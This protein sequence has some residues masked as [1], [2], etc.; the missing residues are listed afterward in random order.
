[1]ILGA[2]DFIRKNNLSRLCPAVARELQEART[3]C[4][5]KLAQKALRESENF[6]ASVFESI[7]D[8]IS[9]LDTN[10]TII[11][12][13]TTHK[14]WHMHKA[15]WVGKK[16][17][18]VFH[19]RSQPCDFCPARQSLS[20]GRP[21]SLI[22]PKKDHDKHVGWLEVFTFPLKDEA[23]GEI[24][25][26]IEYARDITIRKMLEQELEKQRIFTQELL[27]YSPIYFVAID[28]QGKTLLM[29]QSLLDALGYTKREVEGKDYL[30]TFVP[31]ADR[32]ALAEVFD[33][34]VRLQIPTINENHILAKNGAQ[35]LVEWH[36]RP[37]FKENGQLDYFFGVGVDITARRKDQAALQASEEKY[38][39]ILETMEEGYYEVDLAGNTLFVNDAMCRIM[40]YPKE[41]LIGMNNRQYTDPETAK[42][43]YREFNEVY[44]TEKP[45][46]TSEHEILRKDG[47]KIWIE[48]SITLRRDPSG[49]K[50]GF[51][52]IV[53]DI[54]QRK[55]A[56]E[57]LR[58]RDLLFKKL[59]L[60]V[61]G[62]IYQF[63]RKPDGTYCMP[64][65]TEAIGDL[66]GCS[67]QDVQDDFS[68]LAQAICPEDFHRVMASIENSAAQMTIW[69]CEFRVQVPGQPLKWIFGQ[70]TPEKLP[71]G[72]ILWHGFAADITERK[73]AQEELRKS[74]EEL[75][76][77]IE[78]SPIMIYFKDT[79]NRFIRVNKALLEQTGLS[80]EEIEGKSNEE[81]NP[82]LAEKFRWE[83]QEIIATG[84]PLTGVLEEIKTRKGT[85][86]LKTDKVPYRDKNGKIIGIV[87]FSV[88]ITGQKKAQDALAES[89]ARYRSLVKNAQEGVYQSTAEGKYLMVN[90]A[91]ARI[92]GYDS[93]YELMQTVTDI[94]QH[95]YVHPD[96]RKRLLKLVDRYGAV[97]DFE[98]EFY[99]K[100]GTRVWLSV[101]MHAVRDAQGKILHY[102]GMIQDITEK[103]KM[104][105]ERQ[106]HLRKIRKA[107]GA[108]INAMAVAVETRDPYTA[109]HQ[110]RV[111]DLARAIATEM[112]LPA[113][114]IEGLRM[115]SIIHD[116]GKI[117]IP[118]EILTKPTQLSQLEYNL[119]KTHPSSGYAI[120]KDIE[121]P[122]PIARIVLEHH[123]RIDGSG[124]PAGLTGNQMLT[125]SK[126]LAVADVVEAISSHRPYRAAY[127]TEAALKEIERGRGTL[128][129]ADAVDACL[130]LFREKHYILAA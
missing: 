19:G 67:P 87:G 107:L 77:M 45:G 117:S 24:R 53:R 81:I 8:G 118:S 27:D 91:F 14:K 73:S 40:G 23:T 70:S 68:P 126:I 113:D 1:M 49:N 103:K 35:L 9:V 2:R 59:S 116:I 95:L 84:R 22:L 52:G 47:S 60:H 119:I 128:Y 78:S 58:Q 33:R 18:D 82:K 121:F 31:E 92:L 99:R 90:A 43:V 55:K 63:K 12:L 74:H 4:T 56:E 102:Q 85:K 79:E 38:R 75:K 130:R 32:E 94:S 80:R 72:S 71:D 48:A 34:L 36:G 3:R 16:C 122:W 39:T 62:M 13:N 6:L 41:E 17:Y 125:E 89:E 106:E 26:V 127:G 76:T 5:Q 29:N 123:E 124:Y 51:K 111:A 129:D 30:Q 93:P 10:F 100:N 57:A 66:F 28:P 11:G 46:K 110:R 88:D 104:E 50:I 42:R 101:S 37:V 61:P 115:A 109:G 96:D 114:Q 64:F 20:T 98:T 112:K 7:Q 25:G 54:T 108:T 69:E 15:P 105:V 65:S 97:T 86:I 83:D 120:L 21:A 44:R